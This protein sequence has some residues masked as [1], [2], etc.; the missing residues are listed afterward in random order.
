MCVDTDVAWFIRMMMSI[1]PGTSLEPSLIEADVV[2]TTVASSRR[3]LRLGEREPAII[4]GSLDLSRQRWVASGRL[5]HQ[6][7]REFEPSKESFSFR[8]EIGRAHV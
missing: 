7:S 2:D 8:P 5:A 1:N 4:H 3:L 6:T